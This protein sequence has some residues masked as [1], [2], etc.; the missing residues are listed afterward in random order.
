MRWQ[1]R[2][3]K[4]WKNLNWSGWHECTENMTGSSQFRNIEV[5]MTSMMGR[6]PIYILSIIIGV[7]MNR[8]WLLKKKTFCYI[9]SFQIEEDQPMLSYDMEGNVNEGEFK[10]N[11]KENSEDDEEEE[12]EDKSKVDYKDSEDEEECEDEEE[13]ADAVDQ[14]EEDDD[15]DSLDDLRLKDSDHEGEESEGEEKIADAA[16]S[17][18]DKKLKAAALPDFKKLKDMMEQARKELPFTYAGKFKLIEWHFAK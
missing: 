5:P 3:K 14:E 16:P 9:H 7:I 13:E 8:L 17:K 15:N 12:E 11:T 6:F 18:P 2:K 1:W 4:D 10:I